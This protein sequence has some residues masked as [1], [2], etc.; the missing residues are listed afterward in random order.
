[1]PAPARAYVFGRANEATHPDSMRAALAELLSTSIFVFAGEGSALA[2]ALETSWIH[3]WIRGGRSEWAAPGN[4]DDIR[5]GLHCLCN[6]DRPQGGSLGIIAPLTIGLIL[7]ANILVGGPFD[8]AAMNPALAFGP[9]LVGWRWRHH[10]IYWLGP[11][12]G[13]ALSGLIYEY[14]VIPNEAPLH[15]HHQPLAPED[16]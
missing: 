8:G 15:T 3:P 10:W 2:L 6:G 1:M 16:Y 14:L 5:A 4:T 12:I 11:L 13:G 7:A 9:A